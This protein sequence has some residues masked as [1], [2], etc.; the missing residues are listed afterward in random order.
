MAPSLLRFQTNGTHYMDFT[1]ERKNQMR[2][3]TCFCKW[4]SASG[5]VEL[6]HRK[7]FILIYTQID[8]F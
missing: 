4:N 5:Q 6:E 2:D 1:K 8:E 7:L 3:R